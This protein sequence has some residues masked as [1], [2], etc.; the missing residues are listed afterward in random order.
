MGR[1]DW[2]RGR[3]DSDFETAEIHRGLR[4]HQASQVGDQVDYYRFDFANSQMDDLYDEG[5]GLGKVY[6]PPVVLPCLHVTHD[7]GDNQDTDTGFYFNDNL[8]ITAAFD[9]VYR[10]GLTLMDIEHQRFLK[11][12]LVYDG[13]VFRVTQIHILGQIQTRDIVVSIEATQVKPDEMVND[14]QFGAYTAGID[15]PIT[16]GTGENT[17]TGSIWALDSEVDAKIQV[18]LTTH[19]EA[20]EPHPAY[21]NEPDLVLW[22]EN[23]LI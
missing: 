20:S 14:P 17:A 7:E 1:L 12:R 9:Q 11:D 3:F 19:I 2:K 18:A 4:G 21:D 22:F 23:G 10:T 6:H 13:R 5:A 16:P 15:S 8:Y